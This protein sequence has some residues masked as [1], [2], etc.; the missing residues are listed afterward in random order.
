ML[1]PAHAVLHPPLTNYEWVSCFR[2]WRICMGQCCRCATTFSILPTECTAALVCTAAAASSLTSGCY[3]G[4]QFR[5]HVSACLAR[6][7]RRAEHQHGVALCCHFSYQRHQAVSVSGGC[8]GQVTHFFQRPVLLRAGFRGIAS[9]AR[10][11]CCRCHCCRLEG[12]GDLMV[13]ELQNT[14][15]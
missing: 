4:Q 1:V 7:A 12:A 9:I 11:S 10:A 15:Y 8:T 3:L 14:R 6:L 13:R 5:Y 2:S